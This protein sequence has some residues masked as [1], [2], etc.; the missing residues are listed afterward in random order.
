MLERVPFALTVSGLSMAHGRRTVVRSLSF[1]V[2]YGEVFAVL[3]PNGA[4]K[5]TLLRGV[6]GLL[7]SQGK[8]L[9][10]GRDL[11]ALR[12]RDRARRLAFVPQTPSLT[13][14]LPVREVVAH[15]RYAHGT[16]FSRLNRDDQEAIDRSLVATR[17]EHLADRAFTRLSQGEKQRVMLARALC[18]GARILC[19]DE[20][21]SSLDV[22]HALELYR[23]I[24]ALRRSRYAVM[25]V[26][27]PLADALRFAD[28][29]LLMT[30][31]GH[32]I[33]PVRQVVSPERIRDVYGV[34]MKRDAGLEFE[35]AKEPS[36]CSG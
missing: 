33:G 29:A 2:E 9:V 1:A 10:D 11:R 14:A 28:R 24:G 31:A 13:S 17:L 18:S 27:H 4:G 34:N 3:G 12:A 22:A 21:T 5:S 32:S 6:C 19:L 8:I 23:L 30:D 16:R 7:P 26:L 20:P 25:I 36:Q 35:L 15:G